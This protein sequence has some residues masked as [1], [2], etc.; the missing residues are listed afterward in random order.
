MDEKENK[1]SKREYVE[2][3]DRRVSSTFK[4]AMITAISTLLI[5]AVLLLLLLFGMKKC[6]SNTNSGSSEPQIDT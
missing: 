1:E 2:N 6:Q 4:V 5:I 3:D